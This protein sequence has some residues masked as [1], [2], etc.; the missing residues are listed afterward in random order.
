M[1]LIHSADSLRLLKAID[2]AAGQLQRRQ[3]LLL[4][5]NISGEA[6]KH[7]FGPNEIE[8]LLPEIAMLKN[9]EIRG[10]M[11]MASREGDLA[12]AST[13]FAK[14]RELRDRLNHVAAS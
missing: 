2:T 7:G 8:P 13:E 4:E 5:V 9:L 12:Q 10:L 1:S 6:A 14:L 11:C 3:P